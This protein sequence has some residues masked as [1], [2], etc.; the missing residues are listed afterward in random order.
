[1]QLDSF[2]DGELAF[3]VWSAFGVQGLWDLEMAR[4]ENFDDLFP[5]IVAWR[6]IDVLLLSK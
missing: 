4:I 6:Q 1:M 2:E 3:G 5:H